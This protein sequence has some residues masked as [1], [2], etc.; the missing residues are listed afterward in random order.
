MTLALCN[1]A[2]EEPCDLRLPC[3]KMPSS[4]LRQRH[5]GAV[6][7]AAAEFPLTMDGLSSYD[8]IIL[9]DIGAN[10]LLLHPDV[11]LHGKT[12]PNR[13]KLIRDWTH[14]G[15]GLMM[16]GG[17]FSFQGIDGRAR[18]RLRRASVPNAHTQPAMR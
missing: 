18:W 5:E 17:Y 16:I 2:R 15:G 8:A 1:R 10:T 13:L 9:S 14:K 7:E 12:V 6:H 11:W 3:L 4:A